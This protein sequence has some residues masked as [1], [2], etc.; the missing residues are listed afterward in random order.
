MTAP[1][2]TPR[3]V[4]DDAATILTRSA[5]WMRTQQAAFM[6]LLPEQMSATGWWAHQ[7]SGDYAD[8]TTSVPAWIR[9]CYGVDVPET[10]TPADAVHQMLVARS[11]T[12]KGTPLHLVADPQLRSVLITLAHTPTYQSAATHKPLTSGTVLFNDP[13]RF[14]KADDDHISPDDAAQASPDRAELRGITWSVDGDQVRTM[15]WISTDLDATGNSYIDDAVSRAVND[16]Q[17]QLPP[18]I[19]NGEWTRHA[20]QSTTVD[21]CRARISDAAYSVFTGQTDRWSDEP[22]GNHDTLLA[23]RLAEVCADAIASGFADL[24]RRRVSRRAGRTYHRHIDVMTAAAAHQGTAN[25]NAAHQQS[26]I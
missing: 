18:L 25:R 24:Q 16:G 2:F 15:D 21:E 26:A 13:V 22:I 5:T 4:V 17:A 11:Q 19:T 8:I 1:V 7:H 12:V 10:A 3:A 23:A 9:H 14:N 20:H 6:R